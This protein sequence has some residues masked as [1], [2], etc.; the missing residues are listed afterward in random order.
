M[1]HIYSIR[2]YKECDWNLRKN[3]QTEKAFEFQKPAYEDFFAK[4][5][6]LHAI[7]GKNGSGKSSLL[8]LIFRMVNNLS[9]VLLHNIQR[10]GAYPLRY[11]YGLCANMD[12]EM[13]GHRYRI[14]C[15]DTSVTW[16]EMGEDGEVANGTVIVSAKVEVPNVTYTKV[17]YPKEDS[18]T[19]SI[20][21][22]RELAKKL[23][24][25]IVVNHSMQAYAEQDYQDEK[26]GWQDKK[27]VSPHSSSLAWINGLFH[28]N[29]GYMCP[30]VLN[31]FRDKGKVDMNRE[32]RLT[33]Q[34]MEALLIYYKRQGVD[35]IDGYSLNTIK[36]TF[37][38]DVVCSYF[39]NKRLAE[40]LGVNSGKIQVLSIENDLKNKKTKFKAILDLFIKVMTAKKPNFQQEILRKFGI[41][42][43]LN[44]DID[45]L[46][47]E[48]Y[49]IC[50]IINIA[51]KYPTYSEEK[52]AILLEDNTS[53]DF[54]EILNPAPYEEYINP[55]RTLAEKVKNQNGHIGLKAYRATR[56]ILKSQKDDLSRNRKIK[57]G[58]SFDLE[59]YAEHYWNDCQLNSVEQIIEVL[60]PSIFSYE[61]MLEKKNMPVNEEGNAQ[62]NRFIPMRKMSSGERQFIFS[63]STIVYHLQ[64]LRS[65]KRPS[66]RYKYFNVILDEVEICFHPEYQRTFVHK[67][68]TMLTRLRLNND[69]SI[70]IWIVTHSPFILSDFPI[71]DILYMAD[72][73][74]SPPTDVDNPFGANINDILRQSFFLEH[75]FMGE[76]S[77]YSVVSLCRYLFPNRDEYQ[78]CLP[79][80]KSIEWTPERAF[81]FIQKIGE[82][83]LRTQL[84]K[85]YR[86][87]EVISKQEKIA[88]LTR[89]LEALR[90]QE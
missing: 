42:Y 62:E 51:L 2:I 89:E 13:D 72:G 19:I 10:A 69:S 14:C 18:M 1:F 52:S 79:M 43:K 25:T 9:Y 11:V 7:V 66:P 44:K 53:F 73:H 5:I 21:D 60:P 88:E 38:P 76:F 23:F 34:R 64:N 67:L 35:Y 75:G 80:Y 50:K 3:L 36:Y 4:N 70:N 61:I 90:H 68:L 83:L 77:K 28:K 16:I 6:S 31:P 87:S 82:P 63:T 40:V 27:A 54:V 85:A 49:L 17:V 86:E 39:D 48:V 56:Y 59:Q 55:M 22:Y 58:N 46:T 57:L 71:E 74:Q 20:D 12:Y 84:I 30:I 65:V 26:T 33:Q 81:C 29:D 45:L 24:Y 37:N 32:M 15:Q 8:E 47:A 78:Y 41:N